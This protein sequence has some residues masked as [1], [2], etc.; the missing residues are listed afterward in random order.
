MNNPDILDAS[1]GEYVINPAYKEKTESAIAICHKK[2]INFI[3]M[4]IPSI[5]EEIR[6]GFVHTMKN[7]WMLSLGLK[8]IDVDNYIRNNG[9]VYPGVFSNGDVHP[10][11]YGANL[12]F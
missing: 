7:N 1:S 11:L 9:N 2:N 12:M 6:A 4:T 8:T 5:P 10:T 3:C